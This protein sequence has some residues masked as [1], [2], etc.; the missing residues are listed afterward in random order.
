MDDVRCKQKSRPLFRRAVLTS[1][2]DTTEPKAGLDVEDGLDSVLRREDDRVGDEAVLVLLDLADHGGLSLGGVVVVDD[3]ESSQESDGDGHLRLGDGVHRRG[4]ERVLEADTLGNAE[5]RKGNVG[6]HMRNL[7]LVKGSRDALSLERDL[8]GREVNVAGEHENVVVGEASVL[9][10][11]HLMTASRGSG[12]FSP[13]CA[14]DC[15]NHGGEARTRCVGREGE[16]DKL[17]SRETVAPRVLGELGDG[18]GD[19]EEG[20]GG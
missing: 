8:R 14:L 11:V 5:V 17:S 2:G 7:N 12:R 1:N 15:H 18:V 9:L 3:T 13:T 16:T 6:Q 20:G 19:V 4:D 10:R